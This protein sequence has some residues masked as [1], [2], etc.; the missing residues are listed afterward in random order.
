MNFIAS[1]EIVTAMALAG[2]LSFNPLTDTLTDGD[3]KPFRL[4]P[5]KPA[6]DVPPNDFERGHASYIAAAR[7][8]QRHRPGGRS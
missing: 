3:G 4:D 8:R 7:G 6:P 5:P 2:R 1:P